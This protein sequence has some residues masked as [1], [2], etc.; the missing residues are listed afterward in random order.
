MY[1][2]VTV[3]LALCA[4]NRAMCDI[5]F[6]LGCKELPYIKKNMIKLEILY[7]FFG[8]HSVESLNYWYNEC[9]LKIM[10]LYINKK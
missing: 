9:Y 4:H 10:Y 5:C 2:Y 3:N 1:D 7:I 6:V 8:L